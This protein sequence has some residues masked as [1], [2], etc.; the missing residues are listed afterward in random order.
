MCDC[1]SSCLIILH[2]AVVDVYMTS[3]CN[4]QIILYKHIEKIYQKTVVHGL[5]PFN[6]LITV[7]V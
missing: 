6:M 3:I 2:M 5:K 7:S 4:K 1:V